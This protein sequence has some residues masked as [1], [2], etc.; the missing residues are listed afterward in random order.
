DQMDVIV[1]AVKEYARNY[2]A[3]CNGAVTM[4]YM[5]NGFYEDDSDKGMGDYLLDAGRTL[6]INPD[7]TE[8]MEDLT[9]VFMQGNDALIQTIESILIQAQGNKTKQSSWMIRLSNMGPDGLTKVYKQAYP[10]YSSGKLKNKIKEDLDDKASLILENLSTVQESLRES[11]ESELWQ[12]VENSDEDTVGDSMDEVIDEKLGTEDAADIDD[13]MTDEEALDAVAYSIND[14]VEA[15]DM[16]VDMTSVALLMYMKAMGY[17]KDSD[18]SMYDFFMRDDLKKEDLYPMAYQISRGQC[19]LMEDVGVYGLFTSVL[20]EGEAQEPDPEEKASFEQMA[21][22]AHSVYEGVDRGIFESDTAI[23][24]PAMQRI[25]TTEDIPYL[26]Q[27]GYYNLGIAAALVTMMFAI[28]KG[29]YHYVKNAWGECIYTGHGYYN[30]SNPRDMAKFD[31]AWDKLEADYT[32]YRTKLQKKAYKSAINC[33]KNELRYL[34]EN[35]YLP[36]GSTKYQNLTRRTPYAE[37]INSLPR[38]TYLQLYGKGGALEHF[39]DPLKIRLAKNEI[40]ID[41]RIDKFNAKATALEKRINVEAGFWGKHAARIVAVVAGAVAIGMVIYEI[42]DMVHGGGTKITYSDIDMP[43]R[44]VDRTYPTGTDEIT[45]VN[46]IAVTTSSDKKADLR[47]WK[48]DDGWLNIYTTTDTTMGDPILAEDFGVIGE[49]A[50]ADLDLLTVRRFGD[51]DAYDV[52]EEKGYLSFR[53]DGAT[54]ESGQTEEETTVATDEEDTAETETPAAADGDAASGDEAAESTA[55]V[56]GWPGLMWLIPVSLVVVALAVGT[57]IYF[58]RK[59]KN[60]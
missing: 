39:Q 20:T 23:T 30:R 36:K 13:T 2:D 54:T 11:E 58:R 28:W 4:Y 44:M 10:K 42:Y 14:A 34:E 60:N 15:S 1:P 25:Q 50:P 26:Y 47:N 17:G 16:A 27:N 31:K 57:G 38:K 45:Y 21:D 22:T 51:S 9:K 53:R 19:S 3:N 59:K 6:E 55:S 35:K 40:L 56:F 48:G 41:K 12:A 43:L 49:A 37:H 18:I 8:V 29:S 52:T 33:Y 46:Y 7:D 32:K 24:G 5:L